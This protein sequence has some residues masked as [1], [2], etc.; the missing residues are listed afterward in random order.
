MADVDETE[1][2]VEPLQVPLSPNV[3]LIEDEEVEYDPYDDFNYVM[4]P[5]D[6]DD[7]LV[8]EEHY[9]LAELCLRTIREAGIVG[10]KLALQEGEESSLL[11][12]AL[13][14]L[15]MTATYEARGFVLG[16]IYEEVRRASLEGQ[17]RRRA[18]GQQASAKMCRVWDVLNAN[19]DGYKIPTGSTQVRQ[20]EMFCLPAK[21]RKAKSA[22]AGTI[23]GLTITKFDK[24]AELMVWCQDRLVV[25]LLEGDTPSSQQSS[26]AVDQ[27]RV[28]GG[29]VGKLRASTIKKYLR[30][31][32]LMRDWLMAV[33]GSPWPQDPITLVDFLHVLEEEPCSPTVPQAWFQS[34]SWIFKCGG[35]EGSENLA[36]NSMV[37]KT[38]ERL[39]VSLGV[40]LR[41]ILQAARLPCVVLASLQVYLENTSHPVFKRLHS[42]VLLF[43]AWGTLR[44]DDQQ[45]IKR[46]TMRMV[47]GA[48]H[49]YLSS[50]KT[51]GPGKRMRQLPVAISEK[52]DLLETR[53][54]ANWLELLQEHLPLDRDY[55]MDQATSDYHRT[56]DKELKYVQSAS[57][58]RQVVSELKVP[59]LSEGKWVESDFVI[60]PVEL[61]GFFTEHGPRSVVPSVAVVIEP[62]KTKR[63]MVGRWCPSGSDDYARTHRAVVIEIQNKVA[64]TLKSF[65]R[66][67][68][69]SEDDVVERA[70]RFLIERRNLDEPSAKSICN[71]FKE[72][73][74]SFSQHLARVT[75]ECLT[76]DNLP[77]SSFVSPLP[78]QITTLEKSL[79]R[80]RGKV[81]RVGSFMITFDRNHRKACLHRID[82][83]CF[84]ARVELNDVEIYS[85]VDPSMYHKRCKFC[86]KVAGEVHYSESSSDS[87]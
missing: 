37:Q 80:T 58:T 6:A 23:A 51:S 28:L 3:Q 10:D 12:L 40:N 85:E 57:L 32:N 87:E 31:W 19:R 41:P 25:I 69:L 34:V 33:K 81:T 64:H 76:L 26:G 42:G 30:H 65:G 55:L 49:T 75:Q 48:L 7:S 84:W 38:V 70:R 13:S 72:T 52:A 63:D 15:Q 56:I 17:L 16:Q 60:M 73:L 86:F 36:L 82:G 1:Q 62:D 46:N 29:L 22:T 39:T 9:K 50:S 78:V 18:D 66:T 77:L 35:F 79:K 24:D 20:R 71:I 5:E 47:G 43:R 61:L 44:F 74:D 8:P 67:N 53:W 59:I 45:R 14:E 11:T 2:S 68:V 21:G 83:G 54:L 4:E 27:R